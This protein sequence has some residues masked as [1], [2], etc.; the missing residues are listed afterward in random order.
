MYADNGQ[1]LTAT[2]MDYLLPTAVEVP[3]IILSHHESPSP[4]NPLGVKGV[5][6]GG[7]LPGHAL[8][9]AAIEDALRPLGIRIRK[10]PLSPSTLRDLVRAARQSAGA[11]G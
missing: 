8:I 2:Y 3:D 4:Y 11:A 9:A 10:M 5:G 7:V 1:L 6:E